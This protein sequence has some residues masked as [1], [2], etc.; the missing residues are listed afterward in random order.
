VSSVC[1]KRERISCHA[2]V[3]RVERLQLPSHSR[4]SLAS[5]SFPL[6]ELCRTVEPLEMEG[7][8]KASNP[9]P[10]LGRRCCCVQGAAGCS[11][12]GAGGD[13]RRAALGPRPSGC[14]FIEQQLWGTSAPMLGSGSTRLHEMKLFIS[15]GN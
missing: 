7:T 4:C 5:K 9:T 11:A 13:R 6:I 2:L 15:V 12:V 3:P 14:A 8:L 1:A 10:L